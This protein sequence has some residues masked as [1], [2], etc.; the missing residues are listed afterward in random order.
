MRRINAIRA[1]NHGASITATARRFGIARATLHRWLKA[2]DPE[3]P[4]ASLRAQRRGPKAPRWGEGVVLQVMRLIGDHPDWFGRG[5]VARA[6]SEWGVTLSEATV[7]RILAVARRRL[8]E[9]RRREARRRQVE[10]RRRDQVIVRRRQR[11]AERRALW[12]E[13][14]GPALAPGLP[15]EE[16]FRRIAQALSK[17]GY[18]VEVRD[19]TPELRGLAD[20]YLAAFVKRGIVPPSELWLV[21]AARWSDPDHRRVAA[22]NHLAKKF[23]P[24][25]AK[26]MRE[27]KKVASS[28]TQS[29]GEK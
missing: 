13:R 10:Q 12:R 21:D 7:G 27:P 28:S 2:F 9:E 3:R 23:G 25:M 29:G 8:A 19:L 6:L 20:I 16:R 18:K 17:K 14:L 26:A 24:R 1:V 4:V 11:D 5:R 15:V 22:L